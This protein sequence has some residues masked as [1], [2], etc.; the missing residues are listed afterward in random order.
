MHANRPK[1]FPLR[2]A[3]VQGPTRPATQAAD[4]A[5]LTLRNRAVI[6][7]YPRQQLF[8]NDLTVLVLC[9]LAPGSIAG[10]D[11]DQGWDFACRN[12]LVIVY[13]QSR[14]QA[15][16]RSMGAGKSGSLKAAAADRCADRLAPSGLLRSNRRAAQGW[17]LWLAL[18][19]GYGLDSGAGWE[20]ELEK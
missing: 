7:I 4:G 18:E 1:R 2:E 8:K 13:G 3:E 10:H 14:H 6:L 9:W 16:R 12:Q 11:N 20:K 19:L 15:I 5:E 17:A